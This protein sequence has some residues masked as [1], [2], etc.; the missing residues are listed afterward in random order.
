MLLLVV[1]G[2][3]RADNRP[4]VAVAS[5]LRH[6]WPAL[7][8][9]Y[10]HTQM[11][12]VTFG[13]SGNMARQIAQGAPFELFLSADQAFP[14]WLADKGT[15]TQLPRIYTRG[16]LAWIALA[17]SPLADWLEQ[18]DKPNGSKIT[19]PDTITRLAIANPAFAPYGRAA[20]TVL[21]SFHNRDAIQLSLG[22]NA[23]QALQFALSG[24]TDGGI[25]PLSLL[26]KAVLKQW[27]DTV[28]VEIQ[29]DRYAPILHSMVIIGEPSS[30]AM[31]LFNFLLS[32]TAQTILERNGFMAVN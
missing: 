14:Q 1:S 30:E 24:A 2:M 32:D 3:A 26:S 4:L 15:T 12:K 17:D 27:P 8:A 10:Q 31:A 13:S 29:T 18:S 20:N 11:P 19:L 6:V 22:E 7:M 25:V 21:A 5:S 16:R 28:I 23:A 9:D